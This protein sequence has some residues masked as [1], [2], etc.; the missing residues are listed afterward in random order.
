[1]NQASSTQ[2]GPGPR[3]WSRRRLGCLLLAALP[4][5]LVGNEWLVRPLL[6]PLRRSPEAIQRDLLDRLPLGTPRAEVETWLNDQGWSWGGVHFAPLGGS[7]PVVSHSLGEYSSFG[8]IV[9]VFAE[10]TFGPDG[11]LE[12]VGVYK[13]IANAP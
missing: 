10:W 6:N 9:M 12:S 11:R 2:P 13:W 1:M 4:V 8:F 5:L 3:C 7:A